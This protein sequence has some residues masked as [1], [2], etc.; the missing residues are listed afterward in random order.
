MKGKNI[1]SSGRTLGVAPLLTP[2]TAYLPSVHIR[3][4]PGPAL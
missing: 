1:G 2:R 4:V 3:K